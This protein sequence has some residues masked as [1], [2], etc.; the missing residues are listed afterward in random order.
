MNLWKTVD[1]TV[2]ILFF[3][4]QGIGIGTQF[5]VFLGDLPPRG[6]NITLPAVLGISHLLF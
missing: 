5:T 6:Q 3:F 1:P 4:A 2:F